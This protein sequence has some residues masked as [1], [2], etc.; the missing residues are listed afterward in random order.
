[1][2]SGVLLSLVVST[3]AAPP[4]QAVK[5][6]S[7]ETIEAQAIEEAKPD[8]SI[9]DEDLKQAALWIESKGKQGKKPDAPTAEVAEAKSEEVINSGEA[10]KQPTVASESEDQ[11]PVLN[12]VVTKK[13]KKDSPLAKIVLSL[14][15]IV[16]MIFGVFLFFKKW[17]KAQGARNKNTQIKVLTQHYLGPKKSLAI[18]RVAGESILIGIT[19]SNINHIKSLSLMDEEIPADTPK[20]FGKAL[21]VAEG[22]QPVEEVDEFSMSKIIGQKLKGMKEL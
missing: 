3:T 5:P 18:I 15:V 16:G 7:V 19:D 8:I 13:I 4:E 9:N 17:A 11:I 6:R 14:G 22:N 1:M 21:A 10:A 2:L 12:N 20:A